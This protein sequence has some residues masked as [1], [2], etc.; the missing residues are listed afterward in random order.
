[1]LE[2][3]RELVDRMIAH[4]EE[5]YPRECCGL[6][7][8]RSAGGTRLATELH[9]TG[10]LNTERAHDRYILDPQ[11]WQRIDAAARAKGLDIVGIYHTHP[12]HPSEP[13]KFDL[14]HAWEGYSYVVVEVAR[15]RVASWRSWVKQDERFVQEES[16][17]RCSQPV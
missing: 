4:A 12:D 7:V 2:L 15:G 17:V 8:G 6:L 13:S 10:N 5:I 3:D 16:R 14:D 1:M 9:R 11:D